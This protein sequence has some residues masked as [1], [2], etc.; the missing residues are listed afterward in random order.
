[1]F[2]PRNFFSGYLLISMLFRIV[3]SSLRPIAAFLFGFW[4][5]FYA[6]GMNQVLQLANKYNMATPELTQL[7]Y[8]IDHKLLP[9]I[10]TVFADT[11][12]LV[13]RS[14]SKNS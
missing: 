13:I 8:T 14:F 12:N 1:M 11:K 5:L 9:A 3:P 4:F 7:A 2:M 10:D 6:I